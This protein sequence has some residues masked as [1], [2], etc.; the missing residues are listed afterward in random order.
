V[1]ILVAVVWECTY[2]VCSAGPLSGR[3]AVATMKEGAIREHRTP[4]M[5]EGTLIELSD[6]FFFSSHSK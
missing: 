2:I 5:K 6:H 1:A 4:C 3:H